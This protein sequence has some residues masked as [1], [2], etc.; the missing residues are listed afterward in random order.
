[1][2]IHDMT[3]RDEVGRCSHLSK[4]I[5]LSRHEIFQAGRERER[6]RER[7]MATKF[8]HPCEAIRGLKS[9]LPEIAVTA[10]G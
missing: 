2:R 1:M 6:E 5:E 4:G 8:P 10:S 7:G 9:N 3:T